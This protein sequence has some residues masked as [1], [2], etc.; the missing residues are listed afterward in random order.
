MSWKECSALSLRKEFVHRALMEGANI[1]ALC[2]EFDISRKTGY[3]WLKRYREGGEEAL[4]GRS[5]RP[6]KIYLCGQAFRVGK[7]FGSYPVALRP[8]EDGTFSVFFCRK[9][10]ATIRFPRHNQ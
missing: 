1:S 8:A 4:E 3:K 5:G 6:G 7:A 10:V 2:R 9:K